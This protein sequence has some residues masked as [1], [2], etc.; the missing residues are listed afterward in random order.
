MRYV[1]C[2]MKVTHEQQIKSWYYRK[3]L[4]LGKCISFPIGGIF[5]TPGISVSSTK[6]KS[7]AMIELK[8]CQNSWLIQCMFGFNKVWYASSIIIKQTG[9]NQPYLSNIII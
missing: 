5:N 9:T 3:C 4:V 1:V 7:T 8:Y 2:N 6:Y